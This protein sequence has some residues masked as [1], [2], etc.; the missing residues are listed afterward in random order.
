VR[1]ADAG[2]I[3]RTAE[4]WSDFQLNG[5]PRSRL[6]QAPTCPIIITTGNSTTLPGFA[7][8]GTRLVAAASTD[9]LELTPTVSF[10]SLLYERA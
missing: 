9:A 5:R 3:P 8:D 10:L 4:A 2:T 6:A 1:W 7:R